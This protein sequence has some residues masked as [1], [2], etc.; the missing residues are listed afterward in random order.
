MTPSELE[1]RFAQYDERI[2]ALEAEKQANSW[3]TLAVIG[4]HPDTEM[5]L[6]V[7][8]AAIQ[9]LRGK[10]SPEAPAGV[11]AATVLRL[12]EIERQ[13]LKAQQ[14]RQ[15][16]AEAGEAERLLVQQRAGLEQER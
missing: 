9:T 14:S 1:A 15:E 4:S 7:V 3:F 11:A 8:R 6:E 10:T 13:I 5:L 12:L 16:L 2:A